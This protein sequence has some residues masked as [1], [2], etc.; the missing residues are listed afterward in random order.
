MRGFTLSAV[1]RHPVMETWYVYSLSALVLMGLQRFLYKVAASK[2]CSTFRTTFVFMATVG[3]LAGAVT[4]IRRP[5]IADPGFL[6]FIS[7]ANSL[8]FASATLCH[9]QALKYVPVAVAYPLIR[10][11]IVL[12]VL[13]A[14]FF[15]QES[16]ALQQVLGLLFS[17]A[18]VWI[19]GRDKNS[20]FQVS[21]R[22]RGLLLV[23]LAMLA[24]GLS[25]ITCKFAADYTDI[26][27]FMA[28]SYIFST[29]FTL[30]L[31][32]RMFAASQ[33]PGPG[34]LA[35]GIGLLMGLLNLAGFY[36]F[37][38]ALALGPL[39]VVAVVNGMNF[40]V[41]VLLAAIFFRERLDAYRFLG[42]ALAVAALWLLRA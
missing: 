29:L 40:L 32:P 30:A 37:L 16:L 3:V 27:A 22:A 25:A 19:L 1:Q 35:L 17:L 38:R 24:G 4:L 11:N 41:P 31:A 9:I 34:R 36:L 7:L 12:V 14:V 18:T 5:E 6:V 42:L 21:G 28:L 15:L 33:D 26:W 39:S 2:N 13:F 20:D 8:T 10:M 23:F